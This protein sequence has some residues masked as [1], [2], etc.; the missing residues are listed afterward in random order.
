MSHSH[1]KLVTLLRWRLRA[2]RWLRPSEDHTLLLWAAICGVLGALATLA[3]R[4][5]IHGLQ[6]WL[7]GN[8]SGSLVEM[9]EGLPWYLRVAFPTVGGLIAGGFLVWA[10]HVPSGASSD[11]MEAVTLGEGRLPVRQSL[12]RSISSLFTIASGGSIGREGS[13]VQLAA[14]ASSLVGRAVHFEPA[15]LRIL[16]ACGAAA[17]LTSAYNAPIAGAFF[18]TEIVIG[19]IAMGSF[20]PILVASVVAN[21]AMRELP[22]YKPAYE[23]PAFPP[24]YGIEVLCFLAL[25][26]LC[27]ALSP[28]FLRLLNVSK[29]GFRRLSIPLPLRLALG[30]LGVGLLSI[31][32]PQVWGNGYSVVNALLH[33]Q[34]AWSTVLTILVFKVIAT[35]LTTGSGAVGGVFT[36]TLFVGAAIGYLVGALVHT[37]WP[38]ATS[39]PFAYVMVGMGAFLAAS[40]S[41]PLMAILMIFE[42]TLSYQAVLPLMLACVVA[43]FVA[44][45]RGE[46]SMYEVT[47]KRHRDAGARLRLRGI[48][49]RELIRPAE[50]VLTLDATFDDISKVFLEY[51]VRYVYIVDAVGTYLGVV[52]LQ[53]IA[54]A[55]HKGNDMTGRTARDVLRE[56]FLQVITPDMSLTDALQRFMQHQGERLPAVDGDTR[57][58]LGVVHKSTLL[59][60]CVQLSELDCCRN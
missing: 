46:A 5:S 39:G 27:G 20:G 51:P 10:R 30:G 47:I 13:M 43:Y 31:W 4:E 45:S 35:A 15:R 8:T 58:L 54:S 24:I 44:R 1:H 41:A 37:L 26:L 6:W 19:S 14:L 3:F 11:Y 55:M 28:P 40:T 36:P 12:L 21:I 50:T 22:G 42:M 16:V 32:V 2:T 57:Q 53:D 7:T 38:G 23:M 17:G 25:G 34:W 33:D 52:A 29:R 59:D 49:M 48:R 9:A 18:V 56:E 60:A